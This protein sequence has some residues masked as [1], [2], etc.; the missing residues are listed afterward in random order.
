MTR[1][2]DKPPAS[3]PRQA[4]ASDDATERFKPI[5]QILREAVPMA[6]PIQAPIAPRKRPGRD[7]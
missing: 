4:T 7:R 1:D 5:T 6:E 2:K 3:S